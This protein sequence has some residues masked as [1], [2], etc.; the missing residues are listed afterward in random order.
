MHAAMLLLLLCCYDS[1]SCKICICAEGPRIHAQEVDYTLLWMDKTD[2]RAG[3]TEVLRCPVMSQGL[4]N[5]FFK[6]RITILPRIYNLNLQLCNR[7]KAIWDDLKGDARIIHYTTHKPGDSRDEDMRN[8]NNNPVMEPM[9]W[10]WDIFE[11]SNAGQQ[12]NETFAK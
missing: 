9:T 10:W 6:H 3:V 11:V 4:L 5:W 1:T 7:H 8:L 12:W 2:N